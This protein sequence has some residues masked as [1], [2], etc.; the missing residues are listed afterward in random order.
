MSCNLRCRW[1]DVPLC[2]I[3][4]HIPKCLMINNRPRTVR[5]TNESRDHIVGLL[6]RET[7]ELP[8]LRL[9]DLHASFRTPCQIALAIHILYSLQGI[10]DPRMY[11]FV[12]IP[13]RVSAAVRWSLDL[14]LLGV[15]IFLLTNDAHPCAFRQIFELFHD[16]RPRCAFPWTRILLRLGCW[17]F[18]RTNLFIFHCPTLEKAIQSMHLRLQNTIKSTDNR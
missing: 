13:K 4:P 3:S 15:R 14:P 8:P 6:C 11:S 1:I 2:G 12:V 5:G 17:S 7:L 18:W 10:M 16:R 9:L